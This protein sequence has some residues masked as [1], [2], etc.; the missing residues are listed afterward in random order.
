MS[1]GEAIPHRCKGTKINNMSQIRSKHEVPTKKVI[2]IYIL[3]FD[4]N[5]E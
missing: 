3:T 4:V 5:K 1:G 2:N